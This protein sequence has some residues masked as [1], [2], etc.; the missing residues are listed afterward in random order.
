M[1]A[2]GREWR[3]SLR[4]AR[5]AAERE[6]V[7][8]AL[9]NAAGNISKAAAILEISRPTLYELIKSLEIDVREFSIAKTETQQ[10]SA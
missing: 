2:S 8:S 10:V 5:R 7:F 6:A 3:I 9:S 4:E 1:Q